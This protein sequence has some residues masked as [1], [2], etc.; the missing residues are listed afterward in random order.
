MLQVSFSHKQSSNRKGVVFTDTT[1]AYDVV[2]N[3]DGYGT[4]N[5]TIAQISQATLY[6]TDTGGTLHT[7]NV[8]PTFPSAVDGTFTVNNTDLGLASDVL[9]PDGFYNVRFE[10]QGTTGTQNGV[11]SSVTKRI[12]LSGGVECCVRKMAAKG[13][14]N[15]KKPEAV[16][17][18]M[19]YEA[20][21]L[22]ADNCDET[23]AQKIL[24]EL[25]RMCNKNCNCNGL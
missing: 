17:A 24:T 8:Y 4:P 12:L 11:L 16:E 19:M 21:I 6:I 13:D 7:V 9:L 15:C 18:R 22:S 1:G 20:M 23:C 5:A 25:Q 10:V 3:P 14:C 2:S